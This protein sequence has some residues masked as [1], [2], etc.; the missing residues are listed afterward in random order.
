MNFELKIDE[1]EYNWHLAPSY[2]KQILY[3]YLYFNDADGDRSSIFRINNEGVEW[4]VADD[5][6]LHLT[7]EIKK[8]INKM[9]KLQ[10]F[11]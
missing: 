5:L 8:I 4:T 10:V 2:D 11:G 7:P 6:F 1:K 9:I 3:L